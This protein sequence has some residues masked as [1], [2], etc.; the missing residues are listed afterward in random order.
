MGV[1]AFIPSEQLWLEQR[2]D[3]IDEQSGGDERSKRV[4]KNHGR[5]LLTAVRR[6]K[7][8][9]S[10]RRRSR[11]RARP[12]RCPSWKAPSEILKIA[13]R[14]LVAERYFDLHQDSAKNSPPFTGY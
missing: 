12:L 4:I 7:H 14:C 11:P 6:R 8:K 9:R 5:I 1:M 13:S 3:Q 10:T 2:V